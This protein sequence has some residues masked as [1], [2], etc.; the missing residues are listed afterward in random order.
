ML[1]LLLSLSSPSLHCQQGL[2]QQK[3]LQVIKTSAK[4]GTNVEAAFNKLAADI[5]QKV[6]AQ[7]CAAS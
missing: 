2:A 5:L 1:M 6:G 3:G 7:L 4:D